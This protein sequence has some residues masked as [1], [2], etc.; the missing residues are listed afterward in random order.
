M[1]FDG[2]LNV[3][4]PRV[5]VVTELKES[6]SHQATREALKEVEEILMVESQQEYGLFLAQTYGST[7]YDQKWHR[8]HRFARFDI[9]YDVTMPNA[10]DTINQRL[11][12]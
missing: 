10:T 3:N 2:D 6:P 8:G 4:F 5:R 9:L 11:K 12:L 1:P 7:W